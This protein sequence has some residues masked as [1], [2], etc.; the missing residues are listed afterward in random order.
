MASKKKSSPT[1]A[2][3]LFAVGAPPEP[4][5]QA[6]VITEVAKLVD[7][8][9]GFPLGPAREAYPNDEPRYEPTRDGERRLTMTSHTLLAHWFRHDPHEIGR[10]PR[11]A[12]FKYWPHQRRFVETVIYLHEV[13][14]IRRTEELYALAGVDPLE[15]QRD[16]WA[17]VGGQLA[18]GSGKTKMMSLLIAWAYLNAKLEPDSGLGFGRHVLVVAPGL[19]VRDRLLQDFAPPDGSPS[20]FSADPVIPPEYDPYWDLRVYSPATCPMKLDPSEGALVVTNYHQLLRT[21]QE[22]PDLKRL[23]PEERQLEMLFTDRDPSRLETIE[24]PLLTRFERSRGLL[25]LND[26]AHHVGDEPAHAQFEQKA[27]DRARLSESDDEPEVEAMAWIRSLRRLNGNDKNPGRLALQVDLS[28]TLYAEAGATKK[29][30]AHKGDPQ[31]QV[32]RPIDLFRHTAVRYDLKDAI[33][34]GIVKKPILERVRV[35]DAETQELAPL[36]R[37]GQPNAWEKYRNILVTGIERWKKV[38]AQL[39]EEGDPRKPILFVLCDNKAEAK[40]VAN[41]LRYADPTSED[42]STRVPT[43]FRDPR[44]PNA[45]PLFLYRDANGD[46][47]STVVEIHVGEKEDK[48]ESEWD[49]V[50]SQINAIDHDEIPDPS[51]R[52]LPDGRPVMIPNPYNV[53][54]SVMMLKEGWDVRNVK[55]IVP[56]RPCDSRTLTEQT[57]GRGLRKMHAPLLDD[58]GAATIKDEQLYV[59]EH[60]S[61]T[62]ILDQLKDIIE[63]GKDEDPPREYVPILQRPDPAERAPVDVRLP[64]FEGLHQ[65]R[66]DWR[67]AFDVKALPPLAPKIPWRDTIPDS[68]IQ[69]FLR[70]ALED[71]ERDGQHFTIEGTP[72]YRDFDQVIE[73]A[74]AVPLLK[75][76]RTSFQHKNAVKEVC[77]EFLERKVFALPAGVPIKFGGEMEP[78]DARIALGNLA[79]PEVID[80]VQKALLP[81]L[82]KAITTD[83]A[84]T[85]VDI[86]ERQA[87]RLANYQ[88]LKRNVVQ[89]L[90]K[91]TFQQAA[92][93][94]DAERAFAVLVDRARDVTGWLYNDRTGV[95]FSI[96]YDWQGRVAHYFPDFI[97]RARLGAV[98]HNFVVEIKGRLD[99]RDKVKARAGEAYCDLLTQH[100]ERGEPWHY[101]MLIDNEPAGR[102][103]LTWWENQSETWMHDLLHHH[104]RLALFPDAGGPTSG[105]PFQVLGERPQ[106]ARD[107]VPVYDLA[108]AAGGFSASQSPTPIGWALIKTRRTVD[109]SMFVA[110]VDG[111]SMEDGVPDGSFCLFRGFAAGDAPSATSLDGKRVVAELREGAE[112]DLGGRYTLKRWKVASFAP[113]GGVAE[114]EL[115]P[116][117]R[118]YRPMRLSASDGDLRVVAELLD[119]LA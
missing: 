96:R 59:I 49:K 13:R 44:D 56:L 67:A 116:D 88:A 86:S 63:E 9:R 99:D 11:I 70:T 45:E 118:A 20:V 77:R 15:P 78:D 115:R 7:A 87:A 76:L 84:A 29:A 33:P 51:G 85:K 27:R 112:A 21:R 55:V 52:K 10:A 62:A 39:E 110:R 5:G 3:A 60:P 36:V 17:K 113:D 117:N 31:K 57:L 114:V 91:S 98:H 42:L 53:V 80:G 35:T 89:A 34:D 23:S 109:P 92:V 97:V 71:K 2:P 4:K 105:R 48:S 24:S 95:G 69:T 100:D 79:R 68:E 6:K 8:W 83:H 90:K 46:A 54:V 107:A 37:E 16:P 14:G 43:G 94:N 64:R 81:A 72:S 26:E 111:H 18:T 58:E 82:R 19:F 40:E 25:V 102:E 101:L 108:A 28:A 61:F 73:L 12:N 41:Y 32:F 30:P 103:D 75:E 50:R 119:V 38:R 47:C 66:V 106:G 93:A 1:T 22:A 74:Y 65:V 104:E